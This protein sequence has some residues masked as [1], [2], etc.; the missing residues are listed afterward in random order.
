M[1][2]IYRSPPT[3]ITGRQAPG[4]RG[5]TQCPGVLVPT[6]KRIGNQG[7]NR[8]PGVLGSPPRRSAVAGSCHGRPAASSTQPGGP[9]DR[10]ASHHLHAVRATRTRRTRWPEVIARPIGHLQGRGSGVGWPPPSGRA[11]APPEGYQIGCRPLCRLRKHPGPG[12]PEGPRRFR[13]ASAGTPP[14]PA[15]Q[16]GRHQSTDAEGGQS[17]QRVGRW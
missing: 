6:G 5:S 7:G 10:S 3:P 13:A 11:P 12:A 16:S 2:A 14:G 17:G 1:A 4:A 9:L 8:L 15:G